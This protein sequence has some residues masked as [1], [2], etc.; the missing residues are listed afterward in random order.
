[1]S[2]FTK[3]MTVPG[4]PKIAVVT[5]GTQADNKQA[6]SAVRASLDTFKSP[7]GIR[8]FVRQAPFR[9]NQAPGNDADPKDGPGTGAK[10]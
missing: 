2:S 7:P 5:V 10:G 3:N 6:E 9:K 8:D 1:M 4:G